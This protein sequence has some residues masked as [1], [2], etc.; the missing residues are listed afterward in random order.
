MTITE[1]LKLA[2]EAGWEPE[3]CGCDLMS[4]GHRQLTYYLD[5]LFWSSL[6][7]AMGWGNQHHLFE[8][9]KVVDWPF[10]CGLCGQHF[11]EK[12][13][14]EKENYCEENDWRSR[15][16]KFIDHLAEGGNISDYFAQL[17]K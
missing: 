7:K 8:S 16:H 15:W 14:R 10:E 6:G 3:K 2:I 4:C 9:G 11:P 17:T 12:K 1:A 5:P 13:P